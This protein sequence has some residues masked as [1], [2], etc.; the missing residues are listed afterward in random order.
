MAALDHSDC[1]SE[2]DADDNDTTQQHLVNQVLTTLWPGHKKCRYSACPNGMVE[3]DCPQ[4]VTTVST[5]AVT[6]L[7]QAGLQPIVY[8]SRGCVAVAGPDHVPDAEARRQ[9]G[10]TTKADSDGRGNGRKRKRKRDDDDDN[11]D[12]NPIA[13]VASSRMANLLRDLSTLDGYACPTVTASGNHSFCVQGLGSVV[14]GDVL[15]AVERWNRAEPQ[16]APAVP[17]MVYDFAMCQVRVVGLSRKA[18]A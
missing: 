10:A 16:P 7:H 15:T 6:K 5:V 14:H 17:K 2:A 13:A 18:D 3:I 1:D 11:D 4:D 9:R 8:L 12:N